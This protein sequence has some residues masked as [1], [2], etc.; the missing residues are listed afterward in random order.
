MMMLNLFLK[1]SCVD[2]FVGNIKII[3]IPTCEDFNFM[4]FNYKYDN[5]EVVSRQG[6]Q[7]SRITEN[8]GQARRLATPVNPRRSLTDQLLLYHTGESG[9]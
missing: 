2:Q 9:N 5:Q 6:I 4:N 3:G 8:E 1:K 7:K